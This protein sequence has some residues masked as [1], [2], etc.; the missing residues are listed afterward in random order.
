I[1]TGGRAGNARKGMCF[2]SNI[3][4]QANP[5]DEMADVL[6]QLWFMAACE[7]QKAARRKRRK[8][9]SNKIPVK[10]WE[11]VKALIA[12]WKD[13]E[14]L[15]RRES[16]ARGIPF[17]DFDTAIN[18]GSKQLH[19]LSQVAVGNENYPNALSSHLH[20]GAGDRLRDLGFSFAGATPHNGKVGAA[21]R[22]EGEGGH[23]VAG[24]IS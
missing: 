11:K 19:E 16:L 9:A 22:E 6:N 12:K 24:I 5:Y 20:H 2:M 1:S 8:T 10:T 7:R 23:N 18:H 3:E 14:K 21:D 17:S 13:C 4:Q 15:V